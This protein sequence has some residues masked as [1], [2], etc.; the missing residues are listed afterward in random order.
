[1]KRIRSTILF[2]A[3][4]LLGTFA[5][6]QQVADSSFDYDIKKAAYPLG[7]GPVI[8]LD[9][10]HYN[11]HTLGGRYYAFGKLLQKDG[12]VLRSGTEKFT[13]A[14][15]GNTKI[16]VIANAN[17]GTGPW[18]LPAASAFSKEEIGA[19]QQWVADGGSLFIIADHMPFAGT[20]AKLAAAFGFNFIDGFAMRKDNAPELFSR[21]KNNLSDNRITNGSNKSEKIDSIAVFTGQAFIAPKNATIISSLGEEYEVLQ[22]VVAWQFTD[23]TARISGIGLA[24]G[25]FMQYGKGRLMVMGEAA[26]FSAQ[27]AGP[28]RRRTGMSDPSAKQNPQFLLNIIHWLDGKL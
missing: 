6:A 23:T 28:Q 18:R 11:F 5:K 26:M 9:E 13:A 24:N 2:I 10:A 4:Y 19:V 16:L 12:Y 21:A 1:M 8:T 20:T 27:L 17:S 7:K 22:P 14:Y 15:L 3:L 25:A